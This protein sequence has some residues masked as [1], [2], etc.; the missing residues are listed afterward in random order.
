MDPLSALSIAAS[1]AQ[2][3]Q[4]GGSLVSKSCQLYRRG[5]LVD[6][7]ECENAVKRL[8][9][10]TENLNTPSRGLDGPP[11]PESQALEDICGNCTKLS[12]ELLS[13]LDQLRVDEKYKFRRWKSFR[14]ALRSVCSK[15]KVDDLARRI[16]DCRE[17]LNSHLIVSIRYA[18]FYYF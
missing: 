16:A 3:I 5:A 14:Q 18:T 8:F 12:K 6:H 11:S 13:Q 17:E 7:T 9:E 10:L 2:F 4:F 15:D 1:I